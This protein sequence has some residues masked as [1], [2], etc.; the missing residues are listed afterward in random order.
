MVNEQL[1]SGLP[2]RFYKT[3]AVE[4]VATGFSI[5][6]DGRPVQTPLK[7]LLSL[8]TRSLAERIAEEWDAQQE[9]I[10]ATKMP[11]AG[12]ANAAID[13]V[14]A[15]RANFVSEIASYAETDLLC[16]RA[17]EPAALVERQGEIWQPHL[18][19]LALEKNVRLQ[20][21]SG[22]MHVRQDEKE[23]KKFWTIVDDRDDFSLT[24]LHAL[25]TGSGSVILALAVTDGGL[26]AEEALS[27]SEL[28][29][30]FQAELWGED[31]LAVE[32]RGRLLDEFVQA[33]RF[34]ELL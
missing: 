6:L 10:D 2:K 7:S 25:T 12:F 14:A 22:I 16:Y 24:G 26:T 1:S 33:E 34:L 5:V 18:D 27:A 30:L 23:L 4:E 32:R 17:E 21:T 13:R 3:V 20:T 8:P 11:L 28:D 29:A 9:S 31:P 15:G 19:W